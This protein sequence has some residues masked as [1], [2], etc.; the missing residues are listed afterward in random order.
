MGL[1]L[2]KAEVVPAHTRIDFIQETITE[3][4]EAWTRLTAGQ[5]GLVV[6]VAVWVAVSLLSAVHYRR[7]GGE[8]SVQAAKAPFPQ[9]G[10]PD[11]QKVEREAGAWSKHSAGVGIRN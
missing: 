3:I 1:A 7:A 6:C 8:V 11:T 10:M 2:S 4:I 5:G 9:C